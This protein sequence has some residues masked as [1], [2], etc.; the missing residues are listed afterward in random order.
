MNARMRKRTVALVLAVL[1][2]AQTGSVRV[3]GESPGENSRSISEQTTQI[4]ATQ[5]EDAYVN[6]RL[7]H[8][9]TLVSQ[10]YQTKIYDG[11]TITYPIADSYVTYEQSGLTKITKDSYAE[12][13]RE[14][15]GYEG[16][17]QAVDLA[18]GKEAVFHIHV[19]QAAQY[20]VSFDYYSYDD[21]ILPA[22][23]AVMVNG[24][25][26][27]YEMRRVLFE[28]SWMDPKEK[29]YD[30]Y[31]NE[32]V[33]VP[34]K[35]K[36]WYTKAVTDASYRYLTPFL[37]E[38]KEGDNQLHI[39]MDEGNLLLG[40][41]SLSAPAGV[42]EYK[43]SETAE[44]DHL[45]TI[46]AENMT[47][48]N[49]SSIRAN[50]EFNTSL[51]PYNVEKKVL[52]MLDGASFKDAGQQVSYTFKAESEGIYNLAV[53]YRQSDK[54]DFPVFADICIDGEILNSAFQNYGFPYGKD[55]RQITLEGS[56]GEALSVYLT[57]GVHTIS[58][59]I[60]VEPIRHVMEG[61]DEIINEINDLALDI[62]KVVG[63]NK[64]KYR[65]FD[66]ESYIPGIKDQLIS[67]ADELD[68]F[69]ESVSI[70]NPDVDD[71][72]CFSYI[73]VASEQLRDLAKK[74]NEL[75]YRIN[76]LAQNTSSVTAFLANLTDVLNKNQLSID[77]IYFYQEDAKLPQKPGFFQSMIL[78]IK[79]FFYSFF[80]QDYS[81]SNTDENHL[82]VWVN[83]S[84]QHVDVMQK[85]IDDEFT[86]ETGIVVDI[87]IM[88]DQQKLVLANA[89]GDAPDIATGINYSIPFELA[90]RGA[91]KDLTEFDD[92]AEI[93]G[94]YEEGLLVPA[95]INDG[96]YALPETMNF[97]VLFYRSDILD[98]LGLS[99]PNTME[100]VKGMLTD[101][102]MRGLNFFYPTAGMV[103]MKTFHGTTPLLF[104]YGAS[105]YE[106]YAGD[107]AINSEESVAGFTELTEL[108]TI[109]NLPK[110]IPS[111]YQ[112]FRN[113][114]LPIGI[115][116]FGT[117]NLLLNAA[118]EI[119]SSWEIALV[120]GVQS[121]DGE[122]LRY[123]SGGAESTVMF[124][125]TDKREEMAWEFMKWWSKAEVQTEYG[126]TLQI[127]YGDEYLWNTANSEA[128]ADLPWRSD[129][130]K[131]ILAQ[132]EWI[133]EAPRI[134]GSYM[135]E[136]ELSNAYNKVVVD[137]ES[138]RITLDDAVKTIDRETKRKLEE[139]GYIKDGEI[140][141]QY[142]VPTIEKVK[143]ILGEQGD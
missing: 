49:D 52:N 73:A 116:D 60:S 96:I 1:M 81:T 119:A 76:E 93:A 120:P 141:R 53:N 5:E 63:T 104:Q 61:V 97:W 98:K 62:T 74:P 16:A 11:E 28:S 142:E 89:S 64:D 103:G 118:P 114:D 46:Q 84:R 15:Y 112:H 83:R 78:S 109:Y 38:L 6:E 18:M 140:I 54:A 41:I 110:D 3:R 51:T 101:L 35:E 20:V 2:I 24:K 111:F 29:S 85:M 92:F 127:T 39:V 50:S 45:I 131:V 40:N 125:S 55:Y 13:S 42:S 43:G 128:F 70:Y 37:I 33:S 117:Y 48:R 57:E 80:N 138:L 77:A 72:A 105:L 86:K 23:M 17:N 130:K 121:E 9:Y 137:G 94:R 126:Q 69:K 27:F 65:D 135:V 19:D 26:P 107:T 136:R 75:L 14:T 58:F 90:I 56:D 67:W 4:A 7:S 8:N 102:Q 25:Y 79:R 99:V 21:S 134:L 44:G 71:I 82:Q 143:E 139:F 68:A 59:T 66:L 113:G 87:S 88:P 12:I 34:I 115:A 106:K 22:E 10:T 95:A 36:Q 124:A 32:I 91:L 123:T 129:D 132:N 100:E 30:R 108:F 122:V 133:V 47:Y 31:G